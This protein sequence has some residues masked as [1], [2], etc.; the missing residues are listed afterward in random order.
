MASRH[1]ILEK[2][3]QT[4]ELYFRIEGT[5]KKYYVFKAMRLVKSLQ[6]LMIN[7]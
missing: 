3:D 2:D 4:I 1:C 6:I 5:N 7:P